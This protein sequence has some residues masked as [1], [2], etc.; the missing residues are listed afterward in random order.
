M[1]GDC[2]ILY[3]LESLVEL[4]ICTE[5]VVLPNVVSYRI[6]LGVVNERFEFGS[7]LVSVGEDEIRACAAFN[8]L[9]DAVL[10]VAV[11]VY[12]SSCV[13]NISVKH[14]SVEG[15]GG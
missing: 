15:N 5:E 2:F 11:E 3:V 10:K 6:I 1:V 14:H 12:R 9:E 13:L 7:V 4:L 8:R